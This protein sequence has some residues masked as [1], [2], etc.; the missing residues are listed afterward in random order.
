MVRHIKGFRGVEPEVSSLAAVA[1]MLGG[2]RKLLSSAEWLKRSSIAV[3]DEAD[4][5]NLNADPDNKN[6]FPM[7]TALARAAYWEM[8][9]DQQTNA[10]YT[11]RP[12]KFRKPAT[13]MTAMLTGNT[14]YF[15]SAIKGGSFVYDQKANKKDPPFNPVIAEQVRLGLKRCQIEFGRIHKHGGSCGEP[16]AAQMFMT[17]KPEEDLTTQQAKVVTWG[18]KSASDG[19]DTEAVWA[20]CGEEKA[21]VP[22]CRIFISAINVKGNENELYASPEGQGLPRPLNPVQIKTGCL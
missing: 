3:F 4:R 13:T 10:E 14:V 8:I 11:Q 2:T 1:Q 16:M 15:S 9:R 12:Q 18:R 20:P 7:L 17:D 6:E 5:E 21:G 19:D 22:G